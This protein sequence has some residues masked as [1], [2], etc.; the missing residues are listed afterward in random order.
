MA[1]DNKA[2]SRS[3]RAGIIFPVGRIHRH[4]KEG[5]YAD[6]IS[7]DAPVYMAAILESVIDEVFKEALNQKDKKSTKRIT[8]NNIV[9]AIRKDKELNE[10]FKDVVIRDGGVAR[11]ED[12]KK[13]TSKSKK[14]QDQ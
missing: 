13:H 1:I 9:N 11:L 4:L 5:R 2:K 3:T 8:P 6:R 7:S 10:I 12:E 14:S